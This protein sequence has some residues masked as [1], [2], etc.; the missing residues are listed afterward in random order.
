MQDS[1]LKQCLVYQLEFS[2]FSAISWREQINCPPPPQS[3]AGGY[4]NAGRPSV[5]LAVRD[6]L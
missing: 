3:G 4:G 5:S 2:N 1:K 6:M